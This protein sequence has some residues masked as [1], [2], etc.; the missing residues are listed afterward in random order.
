MDHDDPT[1][2]ALAAPDTAPASAS[3]VEMRPSLLPRDDSDP[4]RYGI[5]LRPDARTCRAVTVVTDQIRAQYGL[6]SAGAFPRTRRSSGA[7]R[8]GTTR[9]G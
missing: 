7:S 4:Y 3:R 6:V 8:S 2:Y 9:R 5:F 1:A